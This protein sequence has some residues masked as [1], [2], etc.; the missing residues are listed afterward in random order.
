M[1]TV[2]AIVP[3]IDTTNTYKDNNKKGDGVKEEHHKIGVITVDII[4]VL[5]KVKIKYLIKIITL[6]RIVMVQKQTQ[7]Q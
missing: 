5:T 3:N 6:L 4:I 1:M 2:P 7:I